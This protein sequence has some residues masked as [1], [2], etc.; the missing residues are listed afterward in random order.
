VGT[1]A[2]SHVAADTA[3][4]VPI[5]RLPVAERR[6]RGVS[7]PLSGNDLP[8]LV[9]TTLRRSR[10]HPVRPPGVR[11]PWRNWMKNGPGTVRRSTQAPES[12]ASVLKTP[13]V[14]VGHF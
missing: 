3:A 14:E 7:G 5:L 11:R 10:L 8:Q 12:G 9:R 4:A 13:R 1:R 6:D 2:G